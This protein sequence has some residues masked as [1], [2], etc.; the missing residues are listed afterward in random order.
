VAFVYILRC[1]DGSFYVGS[2]TAL[3]HRLHQHA[4]GRGAAYT[5]RRLPVTLV[6]AHECANVAEA[7]ALEKRIQGWSRAKRLAL[8]EGRFGDL[9]EL[10]RK[11]MFASRTD[12]PSVE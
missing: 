1:S 10:S 5:R 4:S 3:P 12:A 7:F 2:T 11:R 6:F 9:P 8:I